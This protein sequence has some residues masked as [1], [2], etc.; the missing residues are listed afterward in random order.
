LYGGSMDNNVVSS[1]CQK[2]ARASLASLRFNFRGVGHSQGEFSCG[3]GEQQDVEAAIS[4]VSKAHQLDP[5][6]IGLASY[7][8]GAGFGLPVG[9]SDARVKA[10]AAISPP[11]EMFDFEFLKDCPKPKLIVSGS[12]DDYT[13]VGWFLEFCGSLS[14]PKDCET[15]EGADHFWRGYESRLAARVTAFF[16]RVLQA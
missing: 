3:M 14:K 7:S 2:L 16:V 12:V 1:L 10:L 5:G 15:I 13:P 6:R 11:L 9:A 4:F 8:A